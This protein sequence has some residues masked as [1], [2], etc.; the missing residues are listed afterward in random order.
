MNKYAGT[1]LDQRKLKRDKIFMTSYVPKLRYRWDTG[2][3]I[4]R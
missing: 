3:A 4:G 1:P 2:E